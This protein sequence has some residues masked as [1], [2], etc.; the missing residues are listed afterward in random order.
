MAQSGQHVGTLSN[1][2]AS[3]RGDRLQALYTLFRVLSARETKDAIFQPEGRED[4]AIF[5]GNHKLVEVIQVKAH[6]KELTLSS[7]EPEKPASFFYRV[8]DFL[9]DAPH[10]TIKVVAFSGIGPELRQG[11][12]K[13]GSFR[14]KLTKKFSAYGYIS[15]SEATIILESIQIIE[16]K[17][18]DLT[19]SVEKSLRKLCTGIDPDSAFDILIKWLYVCAENRMLITQKDV[20]NKINE[21]G[22][23]LA[24]RSTYHKEW[25]TSV[26]PIKDEDITQ[27]RRQRL[28]DE[29][30]RG[31]AARYDHILANLDVIRPNKIRDIAS[32]FKSNNVVVI[33]GASGQGKTTLAFRYLKD[34]YPQSWR[35]QVRTIQD[36]EHA[37]SI[38]TALVGH[39]QAVRIPM[40]IYI[41]VSS[42]DTEWPELVKQLAQHL[43]LH[44]LV[45]IREEDYRRANIS[46]VEFE[47]ADIDL[48][49]EEKEAREIFESLEKQ[50]IPSDFIN[51]EDSWNRFNGQGPLLEF[52]YLVTQGNSLRDRLSEQVKRIEDEARENQERAKEIDF[53]RLVAVASAYEARL[54]LKP[55]VEY[56]QLP[57]PRRAVELMEKEYLLRVSE[58][59]ALVQGVHPIRSQILTELLTDPGINPWIESVRT[60]LQFMCDEDPESFLL[61]AFLY[62]PADTSALLEVLKSYHPKRWITIT[63]VIRALIWLGVSEY[64]DKCEQLIHDAFQDSGSGWQVVL[65]TDIADVLRNFDDPSW[66]KLLDDLATEERRQKIEELRKRQPAREGVFKFARYWLLMQEQNFLPPSSPLEWSTMGEAL[67]WS[68]EFKLKWPLVEWLS[69]YGFENAVQELPLDALGDVIL[70][71][72]NHN[73]SAFDQI[74]KPHRALILDRFRRETQTV[75]IGDDDDTIIAHFIVTFDNESDSSVNNLKPKR[76]SGDHWHD[77]AIYRVELLRKLVPDRIKYGCQG[78]GHRLWEGF[79]PHESDATQKAG[80]QIRYLP[81]IWPVKVNSNFRGLAE[82]SLR[83]ANWLEYADHLIAIRKSVIRT[84][85]EIGSF[86]NA[87]FRKK[88][89][90]PSVRDYLNEQN[91]RECVR[92]LHKSILLPK[93]AV[94]EWG[95]VDEFR[96]V[97]FPDKEQQGLPLNGRRGLILQHYKAFLKSFSEYTRTLSIFFDQAVHVLVLN[98]SLGRI[99]KSE[100]ERVKLKENAIQQGIK[101][102]LGRLSFSNLLDAVENLSFFH[103]EFCKL[104][105][106]R[107]E[108]SVIENLQREEQDIFSH[109]WTNWYFFVFHPSRVYQNAGRECEKY[110]VDRK[111]K[112]RNHLHRE[113]RK[114]SPG[115]LIIE[116]LPDELFWEDKPALYFKV[117]GNHPLVVFDSFEKIVKIVHQTIL[118]VENLETRRFSLKLDWATVMVIPLVRGKSL[119]GTAWQIPMIILLTREEQSQLNWWNYTQH[120]IPEDTRKRLNLTVWDENHF[121]APTKLMGATANLS[122]LAAQIRD[123][124]RLPELDDFGLKML[125]NYVEKISYQLGEALQTTFDVA[126]ELLN[127]YNHL[128]DLERENRADLVN[129]VEAL[130]EWKKYVLPSDD[131]QDQ[132]SLTHEQLI[133]WAGRLE[134]ARDFAIA[135][136]LYWIADLIEHSILRV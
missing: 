96:E 9:K 98:P 14:N 2:T 36:R 80:I 101:P 84:V 86:L 63:G 119:M 120:P 11:I 90:I 81:P 18:S 50:R 126:V 64:V 95:F 17:E 75:L 107:L 27:E 51:F 82:L 33:H 104:F 30:Y 88:K 112:I 55:L 12:E 52:I 122:L 123:F 129:A 59:G 26:I 40:A 116:L 61:H 132:A 10:L 23:F 34:F 67:F 41:D 124:D 28:S 100:I 44:A 8:A 106:N 13:E 125:Q 130:I 127:R 19:R 79:L 3:Y 56:L 70:G 66:Q 32:K 21:I 29:F 15:E 128:S 136:Y 71:L 115:D 134:K 85:K 45:T 57:S 5:S 121:Q 110:F 117:D 97:S 47:F 31:I 53:L 133:E 46:G 25:F 24:A 87:Y 20:I 37:L 39:A 131:F 118:K 1:A 60:C 22:R 83:P 103:K 113:F 108:D 111:K 58:D 69:E 48:D 38:A 68:G 76:R 4:L 114:L 54:K 93:C 105:K 78:Y 49:F 92:N 74:V 65:D 7:F 135:T 89:Q 72:S 94:D 73:N 35:Y 16:V 42:R 99:A 62:H 91:F 109:F 102:D 6:K 43:F 77:E